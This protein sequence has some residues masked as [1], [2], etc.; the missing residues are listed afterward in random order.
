M[1]AMSFLKIAV[2]IGSLLFPIEI[3][4][5]DYRDEKG[6]WMKQLFSSSSAEA[7]QAAIHLF[8]DADLSIETLLKYRSASEPFHGTFLRHPA[9]SVLEER[10]STVG[11]VSI[12]LVEAI[13]R[14]DM[15]FAYRFYPSAPGLTGSEKDDALMQATT[16]KAYF[17]WWEKLKALKDSG[18]R[19]RAFFD[20][21]PLEGS[22]I[23]WSAS[24]GRWGHPKKRQ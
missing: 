9:R 18:E 11:M 1:S 21:Y 13:R 4:A 16:A 23:S 8:T 17:E 22:E 6:T 7:D 3:S 10:R 5:A 20:S 14:G 12:Y 15:F 24:S 2:L 19:Q